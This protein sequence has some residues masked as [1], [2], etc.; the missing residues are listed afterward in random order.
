MYIFADINILLMDKVTVSD[1]IKS[2]R[3]K[4][5]LTINQMA[6]HLGMT[7]QSYSKLEKGNINYFSPHIE[8]VA[9][10]GN[11]SPEEL[12]LG[13]EPHPEPTR[14]LGETREAFDRQRKSLIDEYEERINLLNQEIA[15][16]KQIIENDKETIDSLQL[17]TGLLKQRL[18]ELEKE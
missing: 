18:A 7:R 8:E 11:V 12:V 4:L 13:Y 10:L 14:L 9:R 3:L 2:V 16:L 6:E 1:N 5:G 17:S 15:Y